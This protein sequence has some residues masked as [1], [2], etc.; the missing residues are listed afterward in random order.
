VIAAEIVENLEVALEQF[1]S[2]YQELD[3]GE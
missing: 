2:I 1:G 3:G